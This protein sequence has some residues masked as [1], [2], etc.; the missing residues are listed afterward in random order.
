LCLAEVL[1]T[2]GDLSLEAENFDQAT[3]DYIKSLDLRLLH[4]KPD[5]RLLAESHYNLALA[6]QFLA[7]TKEA[8]EH[9]TH[10][11]NILELRLSLLPQD[12]LKGIVTEKTEKTE[13][14][15]GQT[16]AQ[17]LYDVISD[18][19]LKLEEVA[20][21]PQGNLQTLLQPTAPITPSPIVNSQTVNN[22]GTYGRGRIVSNENKPPKVNVFGYP[23]YQTASAPSTLPPA[24][25]QAVNKL[26]VYGRGKRK[27]DDLTNTLAPE[28]NSNSPSN[29]KRNKVEDDASNL[30]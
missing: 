6:Y 16:E 3:I 18:L 11:I 17:E 25:T 23:I 30:P 8:R 20:E 9:Y 15:T 1:Q 21:D 2:Q 12:Q 27:A 10:A 26:G 24:P 19:K 29:I 14:P 13:I 28:I 4:L 5:D 7:K 22:L